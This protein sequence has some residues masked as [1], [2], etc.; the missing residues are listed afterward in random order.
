MSNSKGHVSC[1]DQRLSLWKDGNLNELDS[2]GR[3]IQQR[4]CDKPLNHDLDKDAR[5]AY[6][7]AKDKFMGKKSALSGQGKGKLL[8]LSEC[9]VDALRKM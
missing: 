2:E 3:A 8:H 5:L 4:L 7:F 9:I 6:S 1:T